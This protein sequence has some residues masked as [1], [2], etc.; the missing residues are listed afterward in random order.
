MKKIAGIGLMSL[1][2]SL[3]SL[4]AQPNE[5]NVLSFTTDEMYN[6]YLLHTVYTQYD[7]RD[8]VFYTPLSRS[9][10]EAYGRACR[11]N[12]L[13]ILGELPERTPLDAK[14]TAV[15]DM[16]SFILENILYESSPGRH[17]TASLY[18]PKAPGRYPAVIML[19]GHGATGKNSLGNQQSGARY[20]AN[21]IVT[22]VVDPVSQGERNHL[23]DT[24]GNLLARGGTTEH[25]LLWMNSMIVGQSTVKDELWDNL[26]GLDYLESRP[27]VDGDRLGCF[28]FSGGGTQST[29]LLACDERI[30]VAG[31][32]G[33]FS[34]RRRSLE[35]L[36]AADGCQHLPGEGE[37]RLELVDFLATFAPK[38][39]V[40]V[41]GNYC[42]VDWIGAEKGYKELQHIWSAYGAKDKVYHYLGDDGHAYPKEKQDIVVD[43]F[44]KHLCGKETPA[45]EAAEFTP[46]AVAEMAVTERG[47]LSGFLPEEVL[48][49]ERNMAL[50]KEY[51][52][53]RARFAG[54]SA[55]DQQAL[56]TE[57]SRIYAPAAVRPEPRGVIERGSYTIE[58]LILHAPGETPLPCLV[59]VP[60]QLNANPKA[61]VLAPE[62]GKALHA[63]ETGRAARLCA[64]GDLV[65]LTDLRG[66]G[67]T[68]DKPSRNDPKYYNTEYTNGVSAL[69]I[70]ES[71]VAQR[72][73]D[74][75]MILDY[76]SAEPRFRAARI[77]V[78]AHGKSVPAAL[79]AAVF[80]L[81]IAGLDLRTN[82]ATWETLLNDPTMWDQI[83]YII[84]GAGLHYDLP[85]LAEALRRRGVAVNVIEN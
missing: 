47:N 49:P 10:A 52:P 75:L 45:A 18:R 58:K 37:K 24:A 38:P 80:D 64:A 77:S 51:A 60:K 50:W 21:G 15:H 69:H 85:D 83:S 67:E 33:Y 32:G 12:Y 5:Y 6:K 27:E 48:T 34:Q 59:F 73:R 55:A 25:T 7:R 22:M 16:G 4:S 78:E 29:Y 46:V 82:V 36:G 57:A 79:H 31:V 40:I 2:L 68:L 1:W 65:V 42:F 8:S 53:V 66:L 41:G 26:R 23:I 3:G 61:I 19:C 9:Q 14:V 11:E 84:P 71:L 35:V 20:A 56:L 17:V 70:G 13:D 74:F 43:W 44:V 81:R 30:K 28:G 76:L 72:T 62:D 54:Q 63:G 39:L